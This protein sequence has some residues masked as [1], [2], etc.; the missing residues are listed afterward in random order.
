MSTNNIVSPATHM[1]T[2]TTKHQ[3]TNDAIVREHLK[4]RLKEQHKYDKKV[5][6]FDEL[7]VSHGDV[8]VDMAVVNGI[9]HGYEIKSD[10]DTLHR[11]PRQS[12]AYSEVFDRMTVVVG[13]EHV[14]DTLSIV[15]DWWGVIVARYDEDEQ[16][17]IFNEIRDADNNPSLRAVSLARVLWRDEALCILEQNNA[18]HGVRSASR[19][20]I[21]ERLADTLPIDY[22]RNA[23][24]DALFYRPS[25]RLDQ[26][27]QTC[28]D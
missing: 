12:E 16:K 20:A 5:R 10:L 27:L 17:V 9:F 25:W 24:R 28:G 13:K 19:E 3:K 15:P 7:G 8:R 22:L 2:K 11:L 4:L 23:V 26:P 1:K 14:L 18:D 6:T 21:Y